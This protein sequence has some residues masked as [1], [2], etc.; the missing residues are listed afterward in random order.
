MGHVA[1]PEVGGE[2]DDPYHLVAASHS[3]VRLT[4]ARFDRR[5]FGH[6]ICRGG[7]AVS[8]GEVEGIEGQSSAVL[9]AVL[10]PHALKTPAHPPL[11]QPAQRVLDGFL[12]DTA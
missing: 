6:T 8:L 11:R 9:C 4:L 5:A 2:P 1:V 7:V 3:P 12:H 10:G